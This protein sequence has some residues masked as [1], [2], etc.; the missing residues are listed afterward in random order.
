MAKIVLTTSD[1]KKLPEEVR[2]VLKEFI[3]GERADGEEAT[4]SES[5]VDALSNYL[6]SI[7][8][9]DTN[10]TPVDTISLEASI[11]FLFGLDPLSSIPCIEYLI[12]NES[13][14]KET[15]A[16]VAGKNDSKGINGLIGSINRRFKS[17]F[18]HDD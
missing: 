13:A 18:S 2:T 4:S 8:S 16:K 9:T 1:L 5:P 11:A 12:S 15:L 6:E 14:S 17:L 10:F 7:K 3:F